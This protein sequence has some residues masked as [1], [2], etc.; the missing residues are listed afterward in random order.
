MKN[1]EHFRGELER[2]RQDLAAGIRASRAEAQAIISTSADGHPVDFNHP[3]DMIE[4]DTDYAKYLELSR[5]QQAELTLVD[6]AIERL[7]AG[8][9]GSCDRCGNEIPAARLVALP[10]ARHCISCQE[11]LDS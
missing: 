2:R 6:Q 3:A 10:Y 4:G 11:R 8:G 7:K 5:R 1:L 9:F